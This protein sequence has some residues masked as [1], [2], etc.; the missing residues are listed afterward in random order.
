MNIIELVKG[1]ITPDLI[2]K[3]SSELG[4]SDS[5]ISK[6]INAFIP[7]ILGGVLE[8][9]NSTTGLFH[10]I[11]TFGAS[12]GLANISTE[13]Q[14]PDTIKELIQ[15]IFGSNAQPIISKI[16]EYAGI[17]TASSSKLF[18][19]T[20]LTT[21][22]SIGKEAEF[23]HVS[24]SDFFSSLGGI[25]DKIVGL[26][27]AGL[28]LGS[29]GLGTM[30]NDAHEITETI[31]VAKDHITETVT[32][33]RKVVDVEP[34][35]KPY[36]APVDAYAETHHNNNDGGGFWKWIIP[37]II[38]AL[39]AFFLLKYCKGKDEKTVVTEETEIV[40]DSLT[41]PRE[42]STIDLDGIALK[43]YANGLEDQIIKFIKAPEF[44]TMTEDQ[45]KEKWFNF[46]NVNFVFGKT[47]QL[48]AGSEIQLDNIAA[49]LKKY[50]TAKIK[51]GAYSD[52]KGDDAKNK[53]ISQQRA[54]F[55]KAELTKRGVGAQVAGAEGY[56]EEFAKVP[57]TASDEERASDR[58][59]S[60]R[61][62]K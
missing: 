22:G 47:D 45:L 57:E 19:L 42:I 6:A 28:G 8:K 32:E 53:E 56:G 50:P 52:K 61:F 27:P 51:L 7:I 58:K 29:L 38:L 48:E 55:L 3:T 20:A 33:T 49:I 2:S 37:L 21:F 16:A 9:K 30:F 5:G 54:D 24:E 36:V 14:T 31:D 59:M 15:V 39:A 43:G 40:V 23:N 26:I 13:Q 62:T 11:K 60:L 1:Y 4:E 25:K 41:E 46:D 35:E 44:A 18:D 10:T 34:E 12:R 17:S